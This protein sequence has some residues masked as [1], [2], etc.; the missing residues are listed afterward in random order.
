MKIG[1]IVAVYNGERFLLEQLESIA[2]QS[3][4]PDAIWIRD[5]GSTDQSKPLVQQFI[6]D[7]PELCIHFIQGQ[8]V[9]FKENFR[10]LLSEAYNKMDWIFLSDQDDRWDSDRI[11]KMEKQIQKVDNM[12]AI[13]SSFR[14]MN[15]K[16]E[17]YSIPLKQGWSN[18][19]LIP[20]V[21]SEF[22]LEPISVDELTFHNYF[23]G[24]AMAV[25]QSVAEEYL[26]INN[27]YLPHDW[28]LSLI[29]A[30]KN[31]LY[32]WNEPLFDY[33]IHADNTIGLPQSSRFEF[34]NRIK[35]MNTL[36]NRTIVI[37][38]SKEVLET[39]EINYPEL[40]TENRKQQLQFTKENLKLIE[41][42]K[43]IPLIG[44]FSN[45]FYHQYKSKFGQIMDLIYCITH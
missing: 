44:Q 24:C 3:R 2:N 7:H 5:D 28:M 22:R 23:Q 27:P 15:Q 29:A 1:V 33:R 40:M 32:F 36:Y 34:F 4:K 12:S 31:E 35:N 39:L 11:L 18:Q 10:L 41:Y 13:A 42:K 38:Q 21:I 25:H 6:T 17:I 16:S 26:K 14:F 43:I 19:D 30:S 45:P 20:R 8:N 9:G 37:K